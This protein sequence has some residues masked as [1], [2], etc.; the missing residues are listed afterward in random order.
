MANC[1]KMVC[2]YWGLEG[3]H[4]CILYYDEF[5]INFAKK[6]FNKFEKILQI[7]HL[8]PKMNFFPWLEYEEWYITSWYTAKPGF[9]QKPPS[10]Q[11]GANRN[12]FSQIGQAIPEEIGYKHAHIHANIVLLYNRDNRNTDTLSI[13]E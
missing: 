6:I 13:S 5:Y 2:H 12:K 9:G 4:L 10:G 11:D 7:A 1:I 8:V 3:A